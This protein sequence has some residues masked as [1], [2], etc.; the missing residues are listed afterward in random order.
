[1]A[2]PL[3]KTGSSPWLPIGA[4]VLLVL[5]TGGALVRRGLNRPGE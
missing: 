1:V 5:A 4:G 2:G 3:P